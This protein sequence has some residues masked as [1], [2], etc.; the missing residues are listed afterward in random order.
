MLF[1]NCGVLNSV[2]KEM[3][4]FHKP[5]QNV[6][7]RAVEKMNKRDAK[8]ASEETWSLNKS[9]NC[10]NLATG[11]RRL[12]HRSW[13]LYKNRSRNDGSSA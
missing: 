12:R 13:A 9:E 1:T 7:S 4:S 6:I 8:Q 3:Q 2:V 5:V 10:V 11:R